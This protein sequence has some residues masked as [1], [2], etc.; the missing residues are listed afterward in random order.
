MNE[1]L[2]GKLQGQ[3]VTAAYLYLDLE[4]NRLRYSAAGHPPL[5]WWRS[6]LG[7]VEA[8]E[9]N[10]LVLGLFARAP[11]TAREEAIDKGDRFLLYTDGIVEATNGTEEFFGQDRLSESIVESKKLAADGAA[12]HILETLS[13]WSRRV[14]IDQ[15]DDLTLLCVDL[16]DGPAVPAQ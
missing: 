6:G 8:I 13:V 16:T 5:L 10:G 1:I 7:R 11:Y 9:Q 14:G 2:S 3:F 12:A 15:E 4:E